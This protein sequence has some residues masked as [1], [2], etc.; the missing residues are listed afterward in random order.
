MEF[1]HSPMATKIA[2]HH[3]TTYR[4]DRAIS[5]EPQVIRL[6]PA[7][8][9]RSRILAYSLKIQPAEHFINW[10]QD[11]SGN[12]IA[13]VVI[14]NKT[15]LFSFEVDLIA[16][17]PAINPFDFFVEEYA[18][19]FPFTYDPG[20]EAELAPYR[21][22]GAPGPLLKQYLQNPWFQPNPDRTTID[23]VVEINRRLAGQIRYLIRM[24]PGVQTPEETLEKGSGSCRDSAYLLV[25]ILRNLG[26]AAR[27]V[28]GYLIQLSPDKHTVETLST[29]HPDAPQ[30]AAADFTDLHAWAEVYLPGA[31][32]LGL[33]VTSGLFAG[34]G[35]IP[36][37]ATP[38]PESAAPVSGATEVCETEFDFAMSVSRLQ[39]EGADPTQVSGDLLDPNRNLTHA[40]R[41]EADFD[42]IAVAVDRDL[43][44]QKIRLTM[45]GEPTFV[46]YDNPDH[47]E[48]NLAAVGPDKRILAARLTY[49]LAQAFAPGGIL[50]HGQGKWYPGEDL[51]RWALGVFFRTDGQPVWHDPQYLARESG[52]PG[53][54]QNTSDASGGAR[55]P[56]DADARK[57]IQELALNLGIVAEAVMPAF[58]DPFHKLWLTGGTFDLAGL[59]REELI[60]IYERTDQTPA[61]YVLPLE[62]NWDAPG[63]LSCRWQFKRGGVYLIP[64][65][66]PLG[67]RLPLNRI[68]SVPVPG[69]E[70]A[71][72]NDPLEYRPDSGADADAEKSEPQTPPKPLSTPQESSGTIQARRARPAA[73]GAFI[74]TKALNV[75]IRENRLHVFLPPVSTLEA[76]LDLVAS[77]ETTARALGQ[78]V[79]LEGYPPPG[80]PRLLRL[81]V[82]PD[83]GVIEVN[84]HPAYSWGDLKHI[85]KTLYR[86]AREERLIAEKFQLDGRPMGTGGGNHITLGGRTPIESPFLRR[87]D[88]LRSMITYWQHH[89]SLSYLFSGLFVGPT[90]QAPRIDE[91]RHESLYDL[92]LG[93]KSFPPFQAAPSGYAIQDS[94]L[95]LIDRV[96]RN[97]LVDLSGNTHRSEFCI[98]KLYPG[99][100]MAQRLGLVELRAFEMPPNPTDYLAVMLLIRA[101][102]AR[103]AKN[104][105]HHKFTRWG[106]ALHDR[107]M[108]PYFLW[109]DFAAVIEDLNQH[110]Y[111]FRAQ[112][113]FADAFEFRFPLY[114]AVQIEGAVIE[115]RCAL[116]PWPVLGETSI[117]GGT[118]RPV[119]AAL[120]RLQ[121][122]V[123]GLTPGRYIVTCNGEALPLQAT[124]VNGEFVAGVR[125]KAWAPPN[126]LHPLAPVHSPLVFDLIDT[127]Q[128]R[129]LGGCTYHVSHPG[130]RTYETRPVNAVEAEARRQTRFERSGHTGGD[131]T[132]LPH[133]RTNPE[134]PMTLD[135]RY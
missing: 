17:L 76:Y 122:R 55:T 96:L 33:D 61:G 83:P 80:D 2:L 27:F 120:E 46:H 127:W 1:N 5:V 75:Q 24:E 89:P 38:E 41:C 110:G 51:P 15:R 56:T 72:I 47:P 104:P 92:E 34:E 50:Y 29:L 70:V 71:P 85:T 88:L 109:Q 95:W 49:R 84:V 23:M 18:Q 79:I 52:V 91:A 131:L 42:R 6:R 124:G 9:T 115:L 13:R 107:F 7:A 62:W 10:Q 93:F 67:Y 90:S 16:E 113:H 30:G 44:A 21:R 43:D 81:M 63:W 64:G 3:K 22:T 57:F 103:F 86:C 26:F 128:S 53:T 14:P 11:P 58:E 119:D 129:S 123:R 114:G 39:S 132:D 126:T 105:Y 35:H 130:G 37:A 98:D 36:L 32:W 54:E 112:Q 19:R 116:E 40:Q 100:N 133:P 60:K 125:F 65:D 108:L 28:S 101:M 48:W 73:P 77:I 97:V 78:P 121:V 118:S 69:Y 87:P 117:A 94:Q 82:T 4:Y 45:G 111:D 20:L 102:V 68:P 99:E 106:T 74:F 66:S 135:L 31:G 25:H 8:H 59:N 134:Y 12:F